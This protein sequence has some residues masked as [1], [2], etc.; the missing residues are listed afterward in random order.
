MQ[1]VAKRHRLVAFL[2]VVALASLF[3]IIGT[4][5]LSIQKLD[6]KPI[7][8]LKCFEPQ[9]KT[10]R[11]SLQPQC[12]STLINLGS[13]RLTPIADSSGAVVEV[14]P[15]LL[16]RFAAAQRVALDDGIHLYITSGF[17]DKARQDFL[18]QQE[19]AKR[20]SE[21]EAAKWVLPSWYSHHPQGLALDINYPGNPT[22][23]AWLDKNGWQ[24]GLCRV[25]ANEW[26]HF[27]GVSA[28]GEPCPALI[29][30]AI[31]DIDPTSL[32]LRADQ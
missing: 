17:R 27:E 2:L 10:I 28:P 15:I 31:S 14:H 19:I 29:S 1:W 5:A 30:N 13:G 25:Y 8:A 18:Y 20:G 24:F 16:A 6:V 4:V 22:G 7:T 21:T 26:W 9:T 12:P 23:A 3:T 32:K 11:I